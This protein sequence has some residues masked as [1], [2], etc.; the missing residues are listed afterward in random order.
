MDYLQIAQNVI[1]QAGTAGAEAEAYIAVGSQTNLQVQRGEVEKLSRAGSKG[2][3]IRVIRKRR[4]GYAYTSD[5][6]AESVQRTMAAALTLAAV[7]DKDK[8]RTLPDPHPI[9]ET[10]LQIYDPAIAELS[11]EEKVDFALRMETAALQADPRVV[12]TNRATYLDGITTVYLVNS[13]GFSGSYDS[14]FTGAYLMAM[15]ADDNDRA[16]A[17]GLGVSTKWAEMDADKIGQEAG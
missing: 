3:G 10:D 16:V 7:S 6:S 12:M 4:M 14:T 8:Y 15:A 2:L 11:T 17:F 1:D 5:F 9:P 13:K